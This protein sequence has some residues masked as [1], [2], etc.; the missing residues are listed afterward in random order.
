M[1]SSISNTVQPPSSGHPRGSALWPL[2]RGT[3][4]IDFGR[5]QM[6]MFNH[7]SRNTI[8]NAVTVVLESLH[9]SGENRLGSGQREMRYR[10]LATEKRCDEM[11]DDIKVV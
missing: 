3:Q 2:K 9:K 5:R 4:I 10:E 11:R 8:A 1:K 6:S 7:K